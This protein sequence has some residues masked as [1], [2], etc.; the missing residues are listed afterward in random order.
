MRSRTLSLL[1]RGTAALVGA[2]IVAIPVGAAEYFGAQEFER[3][4]ATVE[5]ADATSV[6]IANAAASESHDALVVANG[7][8]A[9]Q[10][11][12]TVL[13][14]GAD[15]FLPPL[16][17]KALLILAENAGKTV[18]QSKCFKFIWGGGEHWGELG[19]I[20]NS[21]DEKLTGGDQGRTYIEP[22]KGGRY[23]IPE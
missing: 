19:R 16:E 12:G 10:A 6:A 15:V 8:I 11:D 3:L 4:T 1:G 17:L 21:L 23:L 2:V 7:E 5:D 18:S 20:M 13:V 22:M 9:I 14:R